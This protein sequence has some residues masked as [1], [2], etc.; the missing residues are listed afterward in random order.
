MFGLRK[1]WNIRTSPVLRPRVNNKKNKQWLITYRYMCWRC[2]LSLSPKGKQSKGAISRV[3]G[4]QKPGFWR[5]YGCHW[6]FSSFRCVI[7][8]LSLKRIR[9]KEMSHPREFL[10]VTRST[11]SSVQR[12]R[13]FMS[14]AFFFLFSFFWIL[15]TYSFDSPEWPLATTLSLTGGFY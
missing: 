3:L 9:S 13:S 12:R 6:D 4:T 7:F 11:W 15:S 14:H 2:F 1:A 5:G 8:C 10:Q